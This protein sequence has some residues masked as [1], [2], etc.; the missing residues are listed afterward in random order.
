MFVILRTIVSCASLA[1]MAIC[2]SEWRIITKIGI[3]ILLLL[4]GIEDIVKTIDMIK[5]MKV[6]K[7]G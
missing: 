5:E 3:S 7:N 2:P 1:G 4:Y 6:D